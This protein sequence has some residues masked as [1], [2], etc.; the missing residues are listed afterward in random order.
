MN[1]IQGSL[2][3]KTL[4]IVKHCQVLLCRT[5]TGKIEFNTDLAFK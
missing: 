2:K 3:G 1:S 4:P 5:L